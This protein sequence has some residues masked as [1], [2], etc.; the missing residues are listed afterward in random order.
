MVEEDLHPGDPEYYSSLQYVYQ[1][2]QEAEQIV[3]TLRGSTNY[4]ANL[5]NCHSIS[6]IFENM[7][8]AYLQ[9]AEHTGKV[10]PDGWDMVNLAKLVKPQG[11]KGMKILSKEDPGYHP[12]PIDHL[13]PM[14]MGLKEIERYMT[15]FDKEV[16]EINKIQE[17][18][19]VKDYTRAKMN[20]R[21]E[22]EDKLAEFEI[23]KE[24]RLAT[25]GGSQRTEGT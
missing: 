2:L 14:T 21:N 25:M 24:N 18:G 8:L 22:L 6:Q 13:D 12:E 4:V 20:R 1:N 15:L 5:Q 17:T 23:E 3:E 11:A 10:L 16:E 9:H 19:T 7:K